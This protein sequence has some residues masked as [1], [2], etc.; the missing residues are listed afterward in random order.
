MTPNGPT[1]ER[2]PADEL[3]RLRRIE[4]AAT[5]VLNQS[6][7]RRSASSMLAAMAALRAALKELPRVSG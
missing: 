5:D 3:A 2:V 7:G 1:Y 4:Q 6:Q